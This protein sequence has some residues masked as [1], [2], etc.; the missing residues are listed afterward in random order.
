MTVMRAAIVS[1]CIGGLV[2]CSASPADTTAKEQNGS[3]GGGGTGGSGATAAGGSGTG[4]SGG[5]GVGGS[6]AGN[7]GT[8]GGGAATGCQKI[9]FLFVVDNSVSMQNDQALLVASF[10]GFISTIESTVQAGSNYHVMVVDTDAWGRCNTANPW[11]GMDPTSATCNAY[12]KNTVFEECDRVRGAGVIH[13][14]GEH[15][16]NQI[17]AIPDGRRYLQEGDPNVPAT[18][19]CMAKVG[20]AGHPSER[21]M[22]AILAALTPQQ[23]GPGGCNQGFLRDDAVLVITFISDDPNY[24]DTGTPQSWYD[25]VVEAKHGDPKAVVV[26]GLTPAFDGCQDGKGPPKGAHWA[27]FVS[28]FPFSLHASVCNADYASVFSKAIP[29]IDDSCDEYVP[30]PVT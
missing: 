19:G 20:V 23:N 28:K 17:C 14:A 12:I 30:P 9:D 22:E 27:E 18:F 1:L 8:A 7:G 3:G 24:E 11:Q 29:L 15:A 16:S 13:P 25:A 2:A 4:A 21:P 10:P 6:G 5:I 26:V